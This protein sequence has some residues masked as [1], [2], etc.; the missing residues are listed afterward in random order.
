MPQAPARPH[1]PPLGERITGA[2]LNRRYRL[3]AKHPLYHKD[4][5]FYEQLIHFP[6]VLCDSHGYVTYDSP[7]QFSN[8]PALSIGRKVNVH[9]GLNS[10]PRYRRFPSGGA[11]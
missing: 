7:K 4:G 1:Q 10:H 11:A 3:G 6:G 9:G 8:D 2:S 5:T